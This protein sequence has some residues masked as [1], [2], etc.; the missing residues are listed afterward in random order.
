METL[1]IHEVLELL[2]KKSN[3]PWGVF[4]DMQAAGWLAG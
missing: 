3:Q 1:T 4:S 2:G